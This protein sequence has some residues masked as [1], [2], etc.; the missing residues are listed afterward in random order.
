MHATEMLT[1][2][3]R[4]AEM[5]QAAPANCIEACFDCEQACTACA[6]ACLGEEKLPELA[7]CIRLN[8]DC[9]DAC[10][11]AG[12]MLSRQTEPEWGV[13]RAQLEAMAQAVRACG[14]ECR[15]HAAEHEHC[16]VCAET[17]RRCDDACERL[18]SEMG[19]AA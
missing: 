15:R 10:G 2:H 11:A 5:D 3:P 16:R 17:C 13:L 7:H 6:D 19:A 1:T 9:A 12:R 18:M 4:Q 8:L 14:N